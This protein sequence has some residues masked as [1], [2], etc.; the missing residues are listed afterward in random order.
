VLYVIVGENMS[1]DICFERIDYALSVGFVNFFHFEHLVLF[2][3]A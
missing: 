2:S 3:F 1:D